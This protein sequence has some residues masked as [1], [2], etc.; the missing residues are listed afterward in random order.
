M[1]RQ[2]LDEP[3]DLPG[4][5]LHTA[6]SLGL[7]PE[8]AVFAS[9]VLTRSDPAVPS[10]HCENGNYGLPDAVLLYAMVR[11]FKPRR[12]V[13]VGSGNSTLVV[14]AALG[15]NRDEHQPCEHLCIEPYEMPWL[16][17]AG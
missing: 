6:D 17:A 14:N 3:R 7:I 15:R 1:L 13:E 5:D 16:E 2:P 12:V 10:Y 4:L 8:L 11:H 9:E